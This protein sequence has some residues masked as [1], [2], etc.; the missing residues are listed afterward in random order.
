MT[1]DNKRKTTLKTAENVVRTELFLYQSTYCNWPKFD[2]TCLYICMATQKIYLVR[3]RSC[4]WKKS[5]WV[6]QRDQYL[7]STLSITVERALCC[8]EHSQQYG[9]DVQEVFLVGRL[10]TDA[11][12]K[13]IRGG[14]KHLI[15]GVGKIWESYQDHQWAEKLVK[16]RC[17]RI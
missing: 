13:L 6:S 10:E 15:V 9:N 14:G 7:T 12:V 3:H 4:A 16:L 1:F 5:W 17:K 2:S 11:T 8:N